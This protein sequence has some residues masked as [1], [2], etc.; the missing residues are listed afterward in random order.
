M[1]WYSPNTPAPSGRTRKPCIAQHAISG[2]THNTN[3]IKKHAF[4]QFLPYQ[5][6]LCCPFLDLVDTIPLQHTGLLTIPIEIP[7]DDSCCINVNMDCNYNC[8]HQLVLILLHGRV[9]TI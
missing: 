4:K 1:S 5:L 3:L 2:V 7:N 6:S 8:M 9:A